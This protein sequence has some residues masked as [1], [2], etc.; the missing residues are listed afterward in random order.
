MNDK[1]IIEEMA[2]DIRVALEIGTYENL[3]IYIK[4][5]LLTGVRFNETAK[6]L[7]NK[8]QPKIPEG[9]VVLTNEEYNEMV[10]DFKQMEKD[11]KDIRD[12]TIKEVLDLADAHNN[13]FE[14]DMERFIN[15]LKEIY[16]IKEW[17]YGI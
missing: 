16:N 9:S 6:I 8:Y 15:H 7:A 2:R 3:P 10:E 5:R 11:L 12:K 14:S 1:E 13:G 17:N 4:D